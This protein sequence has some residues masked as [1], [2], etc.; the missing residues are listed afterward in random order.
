MIA[1][2]PSA[3][4]RLTFKAFG[5]AFTRVWSYPLR[6]ASARDEAMEIAATLLSEPAGSA[7]A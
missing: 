6:L 4:K 2:E 5:V 1:I 3:A 7:T